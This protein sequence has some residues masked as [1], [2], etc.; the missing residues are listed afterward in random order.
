MTLSTCKQ[1]D[2]TTVQGSGLT[3][4]F[5]LIGL[6]VV[7]AIIGIL[8]SLL[9]PT[10]STAKARAKRAQCM[11]TSASSNVAFADGSVRFLKYG[12]SLKPEN[13]WSVTD[14]WR[15]LSSSDKFAQP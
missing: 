10:L 7:I 2:R 5:S 14:E 15:A 12:T 6:L 3:G 4:A 13:L 9:L 1:E 11:K 8:A